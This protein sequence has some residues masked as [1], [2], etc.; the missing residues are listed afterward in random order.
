MFWGK[1]FKIVS[2]EFQSWIDIGLAEM[3][4]IIAC[5]IEYALVTS[6]FP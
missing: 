6:D 5:K 3:A 1:Y 2:N 4:M